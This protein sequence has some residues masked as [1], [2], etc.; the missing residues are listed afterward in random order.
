MRSVARVVGAL[1]A[2]LASLAV[3]VPGAGAAAVGKDRVLAVLVSYGSAQ[4]YARSVVSTALAEADAFF[5]RSSYGKLSLVATVTPW[6]D[7]GPTRPDCGGS[8]RSFVPL[9]AVASAAGY[10]PAKYDSVIYVVDG[11]RCGFH[12]IEHG[13]DVL[14][15][16]EPD[17]RLIVHE[18]GHTFG[19]PHAAAVSV[20]SALCVTNETGD[21]F[22]PMG[23][24]FVD[25][26]AYEKEQL[27]WI[28]RQPRV[29]RPGAYT[30][31][32]RTGRSLAH[33]AV[34]LEMPDAEYWLEQRPDTK[35]PALIVHVVHPDEPSSW[36]IAPSTLLL[37]PIR[38]GHVTIT[39]GQTFRVRG[40]FSVKVAR[41]LAAPMR[42]L[43]TLH[44]GTH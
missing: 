26:N 1:G 31:Y 20:C 41:K 14:L 3:V 35:T 18:L 32:P 21:L 10:D 17:Q 11:V 6:L 19:L 13:S 37:A 38:P 4:P 30:V 2:I 27:G 44:G 12:G 28:P 42:L 43:L 24:G 23:S 25:F 40:E 33:Q 9:R 39:P 8:D 16:T 36:P 22:S 15:V 7:G 34:V 29:S 5:R